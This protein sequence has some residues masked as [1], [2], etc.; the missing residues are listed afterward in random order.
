MI[1]PAIA[2]AADPAQHPE[3]ASD[4]GLAPWQVK[5]VY[6]VLP[7]GARGDEMLAAGR[8]SPWLGAAL[9]DYVSPARR[10]LIRAAHN[11]ARY[12]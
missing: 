8:F 11:A 9:S 1:A 12:L 10:L 7:P 6:G 5:K 2:A 3:L 4:V